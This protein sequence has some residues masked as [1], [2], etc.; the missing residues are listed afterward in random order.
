MVWLNLHP[1]KIAPKLTVVGEYP[2][3]E[4][5]DELVCHCKIYRQYQL[6]CAH[7]FQW[8]T[9]S[10]C[11][12]TE[13]WRT[14]ASYFDDCGFEFYEGIGKTYATKEVHEVIG[15]P[16][17]HMLVVREVL[18][19]I[20]TRF[21]DLEELTAEWE[22]ERRKE[23]ADKWVELLKKYTDPIRKRLHDEHS[24]SSKT[25]GMISIPWLH[26]RILYGTTKTTA[27]TAKPKA[28]R[29]QC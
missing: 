16:S 29:M 12:T 24:M 13:H 11:I 9:L 1:P 15:G 8:D 28:R 3:E 6:P 17:K 20:K 23:A 4:L 22:P 10:S 21:Y 26:P 19:H 7:I 2:R 5:E 27:R 25:T 18:D 14:W